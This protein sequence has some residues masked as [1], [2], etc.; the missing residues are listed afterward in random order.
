MRHQ[1]FKLADKNNRGELYI[2]EWLPEN[3]PQQVICLVH[4]QSEHSGRYEHVASFFVERGIGLIAIDLIGHGQ[5]YGRRGHVNSLQDY[6]NNIQV[7][8]EESKKRHPSSTLI[9]YGHS[10]GGNV[11]ANYALS[12]HFDQDIAG[13]VLTSPWFKLAFAPPAF[14]EMLAGVMNSIYPAFT[15][16]N[17]LTGEGLSRDPKVGPAYVND[18]LVHG[19]IS[20]GAYYSCREGGLNALAQ[21][22]KLPKPTLVL[23]G[24]ADPIITHEGS[25]EFVQKAG[26]QAQLIEFE[27]GYHELHN[28]LEWEK[29]LSNVLDWAKGIN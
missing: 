22:D 12:T 16:K 21:A 25:R 29:A 14:K 17:D 24:T 11:V 3:T 7:F 27:G 19:K 1:T 8:I 15:E 26:S 23:H 18:P 6:L 20:A 10:M 5:S 9:I 28:D 13:I 4:G 2:Q